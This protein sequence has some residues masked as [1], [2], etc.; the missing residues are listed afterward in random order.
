VTRPVSSDSTRRHYRRIGA[1]RQPSDVDPVDQEGD[2]RTQGEIEADGVT[3][4]DPSAWIA[5]VL[6][7]SDPLVDV[8]TT[9][10]WTCDVDEVTSIE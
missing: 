3:S 2:A 9:L 8:A 10:V 7:T 6:A 1:A 4:I 5:I